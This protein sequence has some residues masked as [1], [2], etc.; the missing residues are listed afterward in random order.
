[1]NGAPGAPW[2]RT[3]RQTWYRL[4]SLSRA[5][6]PQG[7]AVRVTPSGPFFDE[8]SAQRYHAAG[9]PGPT[10]PADNGAFPL[11]HIVLPLLRNIRKCR[12]GFPPEMED[13]QL[14]PPFSLWWCSNFLIMSPQMVRLACVVCS[15][16]K[17]A[18]RQTALGKDTG[19]NSKPGTYAMQRAKTPCTSPAWDASRAA[20]LVV[21]APPRTLHIIHSAQAFDTGSTT[22]CTHPAAA[23]A[24]RYEKNSGARAAAGPTAS[25][26]TARATGAPASPAWDA[27]S[28][29]STH[30]SEHVQGRNH[31]NRS[32][33]VPDAS[34][35]VSPSRGEGG[36]Q[37]RESM[38]EK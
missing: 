8:S 19:V 13:S 34:S 25:S 35:A 36:T 31:E 27:P 29:R 7:S 2:Y 18:W 23:G 28:P 10:D 16:C 32:G 26:A 38:P 24:A 1:M 5:H 3:C 17:T 21:P 15:A 33:H 22:R 30:A 37:L 11:A 6:L 4:W 20:P 9:C 14:I 12:R